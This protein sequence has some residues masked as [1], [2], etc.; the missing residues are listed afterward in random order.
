[1]KITVGYAESPFSLSTQ[2]YQVVGE[3]KEGGYVVTQLPIP[4]VRWDGTEYMAHGVS[5]LSII[6][7]MVD[8]HEEEINV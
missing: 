8:I 1:M 2:K 6:K 7:N 3:L 5:G 4:L